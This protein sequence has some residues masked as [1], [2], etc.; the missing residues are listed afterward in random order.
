M[1][2]LG[3]VRE[4]NDDKGFGFIT[5]IEDV[6]SSERTFFHIRD[7]ERCGRRPEINELVRYV[8]TRQQDGRTRAK[9]VRRAVQPSR[10]APRAGTNAPRTPSREISTAAA[11]LLISTYASGIAWAIATDRL[12][13]VIAFALALM[14][15]AA[16]MAYALDKHAAERGR[17]RIQEST[18]HGLEM[19]GGWPGALLAQRVMRHKTRKSSYRNGFWMSV[20][21]NCAVLAGWAFWN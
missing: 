4:W 14:S 10:A 12:P 17:W 1:E 11:L 13:G 15:V 21:V 2:Q 16:Y 6:G 3:K 19:L 7:Y 9:S 8:P 5:A 20:A 18:L